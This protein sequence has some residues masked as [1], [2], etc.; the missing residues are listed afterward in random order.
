MASLVSVIIPTHNRASVI[1]QS[2]QSVLRQTYSDVEV[3]VVD[4]ASSDT[5]RMEIGRLQHE[6]PRVR[7]HELPYRSGAQ[8]ARNAGLRSARGEWVAFLDSDDR[9][10]PRSIEMRMRKVVEDEADVVHSEGYVLEEGAPA[11][12][13]GVPPLEGS[14]YRELLR[15]PGP[16]FQALLTRRSAF[17]TIGYLDEEIVSYQE[18]DTTIRLAQVLDRWSFVPEPTFYWDVTRADS[19]S[20]DRRRNAQGY[21]QVVTKHRRAILRNLGP[22][23]LAR[24]YRAIAAA[25]RVAGGKRTGTHQIRRRLHSAAGRL[26][27]IKGPALPWDAHYDKR[28]WDFIEKTLAD[29]DLMS[30]F[31][32]GDPLPAGFGKGLD[33]RCVEYPWCLANLGPEARSLLDAGSTLNFEPIVRHP[34]LAG[35]VLHIMTLAPERNSFWKLGISYLFGDLRD[36]PIKSGFYGSIACLSTLEHVGFDNR[37][38]THANQSPTG[39]ADD[40]IPV[41]KELR[42]VLAPGGTLLLTVPF[43][44][45]RNFGSF[46]VFD[47]T[48]VER[49]M[50]AFQ[51]AAAMTVQF[52][53]YTETGWEAASEADCVGSEYVEWVARLHDEALPYR[54]PVEHDHAAAARA[55]ACIRLVKPAD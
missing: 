48:L 47:S 45:Y 17:E 52:F 44:V 43:G 41:I 12:V 21:E 23:G 22:L 9:W 32:T 19:I 49:T 50:S 35:R 38:Y 27:A 28:K 51:P 31:R 30:R 7:L 8:A 10:V 42:R 6:D 16:M 5:T 25:Y 29:R 1:R 3:I 18:W 39:R 46:Q 54:P 53:R 11:R 15:R 4:D 40:Y 20:K 33:E 26:A 55:I 2:V 36:I 14:V 37:I 34:A 24:H 13:F